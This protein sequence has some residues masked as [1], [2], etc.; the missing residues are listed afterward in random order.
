[1]TPAALDEALD[2]L[3]ARELDVAYGCLERRFHDARYPQIPHTWARLRE[4]SFC[5]GGVSA[6]RPRALPRLAAVMDR[7]GAARKSPLRL[8]GIFGWDVLARFATG[9]L[10]LAAAEARA[11]A[12]VGAPAGALCC[13]HPEIAVNVDRPADVALAEALIRA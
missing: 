7:L 1:L 13:T 8:A 11:S 12:L 2:L 9:T 3:A 4:G 10:T 6:L 5:G